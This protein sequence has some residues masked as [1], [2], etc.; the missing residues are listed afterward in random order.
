M[1]K[2][3][4]N[5]LIKILF[6]IFVIFI[7]FLITPL[8]IILGILISKCFLYGLICLPTSFILFSVLNKYYDV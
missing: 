4:L 7:V 6:N 3:K 2:K 5:P 8:S 1:K